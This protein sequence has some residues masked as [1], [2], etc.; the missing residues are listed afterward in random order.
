M[1]ALTVSGWLSSALPSER[2]VTLSAVPFHLFFCG[3]FALGM[4]AH[5]ALVCRPC[6]R[7]E[8]ARV[9]PVGRGLRGDTTVEFLPASLRKVKGGEP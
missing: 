5:W 1:N 9:A 3:V 7:R 4:L 8:F 2:V 6:C